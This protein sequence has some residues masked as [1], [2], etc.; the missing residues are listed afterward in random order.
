MRQALA[1]VQEELQECA[2]YQAAPLALIA[3]PEFPVD[4]QGQG[5]TES[6]NLKGLERTS[7]TI[8]S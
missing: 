3:V 2:R 6:Q 5:I 7:T 4:A 8:Q 1:E